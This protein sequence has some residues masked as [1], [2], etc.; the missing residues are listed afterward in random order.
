MAFHSTPKKNTLQPVLQLPP[1]EVSLD[2]LEEKYAKTAAENNPS[3][4]RQRVARG[5]AVAEKVE[6]RQHWEERFV[7]AMEN[8]FIP[9]GRISSA[10]GTD[11]QATLINCYVVPVGDAVSED[12]D[13]KP[14]IYKALAQAA[15]TMRRGGGVGYNFSAI[16]PKNAKVKGTH[17]Q[18][19]GPISYMRVFDRSCETVE[20]AGARRG[21]QMGML[22]IDHPDVEDFIRSKDGGD[23]TNFNISVAVTESF[24]LAVET[25]GDWQLV[26]KA[27]PSDASILAGSFLRADGLWVYKTLKART[28]WNQIMRSTYDHAE[29]GIIFIDNVNHDNNLSY[30]EL[31]EATN[32]CAEEPLPPY[33][34]CCLGSINLTQFV[35]DPFG[36]HPSFDY[37]RFETVIKI[38][39]RM[40]DNVLDV[41][42]WPLAEQDAESKSKRRVGLGYTG[43][44]D[45]LIMLKKRYNSIEALQM[46]R[47]I[48]QALRDCAYQA[49]SDLARERGSFPL[50]DAQKYLGGGFASRLP[51]A[52]QQKILEQGMRNSH[53]LAIAPTGTISL[54]F[55]DN[56]SNGIE[57]PFSWTYNRK[58]RL[59]EGG[60]KEYAVEDYAWRLYRAM[61][62]DVNELPDYFVTALQISA[63][64]HMDMVAAANPFID[65]AISK[66]VNVPEDDPYELFK[67]LYFQAWKAGL[68]GL[69]TYRP[70]S[71]LGAV[72][73]TG[74]EKTLKGQAPKAIEDF[75]DDVNRRITIKALPEPVLGSLRWPD[76]PHFQSGNSSWTYMIEHPDGD[77][78]L[79]VGEADE[80]EVIEQG[81]P[82][83]R[84]PFEVWV[85]GRKTPQGLGAV[86]KTLS[87]DMRSADRGWMLKKLDALS[88]TGGENPFLLPMPPDGQSVYVGSACQAI[89]KIMLWRADQLGVF[90]SEDPTPQE[91]KPW[92]TRTPLLDSLFSPKEPKTGPGGTVSWCVDV[93][94]P[95]TG[96]DFVLG[97]KEISLPDGTHRPYSMWLSGIYPRALDGL[98]KLISLDMRVLDP[99]WI[100][101]KLRKLT[102]YAEP[103][104]EFMAKIPGHA[105]GKSQT[106][107]STVAY[108]AKL[109]LQRYQQLSILDAEGNPLDNMGLMASRH[110]EA[111]AS[112]P[113]VT[114]SI[115]RGKICPDCNAPAVIK[116][117]GCEFCTA[118][119]K[120]GS[121]G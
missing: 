91:E 115:I 73:T 102:T 89:G 29:P 87:I 96:D 1:Q 118:C 20:S 108:I 94:N 119:G 64:D 98:C 80:S 14:S 23:L 55:A 3:A 90:E 25:D 76:R 31:I 71:T 63:K 110:E 42:F 83:K 62:G 112:S 57:P 4:I 51:Q 17:S 22:N 117:D 8:G 107:P 34:C 45:A 52:V 9:A 116:K 38:S 35:R 10:A 41:T 2:V 95:A 50:F 84:V 69:A 70:N 85:Q 82:G 86:A 44:G 93:F 104:S 60:H 18:A 30:C 79:F 99:S 68:K 120:T 67:D 40:L 92:R 121:C 5:L 101:L 16:R 27:E 48:T 113:N 106:Y 66:T 109:M 39:V 49:S 6:Q 77:F 53:L 43:L 114:F 97:L 19:S 65:S 111:H 103:L 72:L 11:I 46:C 47:E 28:L 7:F 37:E 75:S 56:A 78:A 54:A 33:G 59:A 24:M 32:P 100:G 61:G 81:A 88:K 15:E 74:T 36:D 21:A 105:D 26:H 13:G 58:K 12:K